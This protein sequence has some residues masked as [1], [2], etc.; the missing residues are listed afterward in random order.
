[1]NSTFAVLFGVLPAFLLVPLT[2]FPLI[3]GLAEIAETP[4]WGALSVAW[5]VG[6]LLGVRTLL[7]VYG[8]TYTENTIP[9]LLAGIAAAAPIVWFTVM[10]FGWPYSLLPLY[11]SAGPVI[12]AVGYIVEI[13]FFESADDARIIEYEEV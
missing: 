2:I 9:G 8:G 6:G 3:A 11:F 10:Y 12:V 4:G 13:L 1:M 7:Q 5:A